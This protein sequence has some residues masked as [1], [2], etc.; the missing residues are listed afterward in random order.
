MSQLLASKSPIAILSESNRSKRSSYTNAF[1]RMALI[2][3][4]YQNELRFIF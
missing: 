2:H 4:D 1:R 3:F